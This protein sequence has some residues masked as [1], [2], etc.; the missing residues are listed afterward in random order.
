MSIAATYAASPVA[1]RTIAATYAAASTSNRTRGVCR[2]DRPRRN[3]LWRDAAAAEGGAEAATRRPRTESGG[4]RTQG[5]AVGE[6][7]RGHAGQGSRIGRREKRPRQGSKHDGPG[8]IHRRGRERQ[9]VD[10]RAGR[11]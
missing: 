7:A 9:T 1:P 8:A 6:S 5:A 11:R 10:A 2:R 3:R 4:A